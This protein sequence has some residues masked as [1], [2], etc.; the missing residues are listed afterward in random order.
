MFTWVFSVGVDNCV[1]TCWM[2]KSLMFSERC[3]FLAQFEGME[4]ISWPGKHQSIQRYVHSSFIIL[5]LCFSIRMQMAY[6]R[7]G[8]WTVKTGM[9][10]MVK[11]M[12]SLQYRGNEAIS[13]SLYQQKKSVWIMWITITRRGGGLFHLLLYISYSCRTLF[14]WGYCFYIWIVEAYCR[15]NHNRNVETCISVI[16]IIC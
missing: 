4:I 16:L 10:M 5:H 3:T 1:N 9:K 13:F 14:W 2:S 8:R 7:I 15:E 12:W 11:Q 6:S